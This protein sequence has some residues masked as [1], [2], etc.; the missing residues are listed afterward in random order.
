MDLDD[1]VLYRLAY[2]LARE[3]AVGERASVA[4]PLGGR[5]LLRL[6]QNTLSTVISNMASTI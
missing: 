6:D 3:L 4:R 1:C 5:A 2:G